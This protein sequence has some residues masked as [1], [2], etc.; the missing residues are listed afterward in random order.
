MLGCLGFFGSLMCLVSRLH[1][2]TAVAVEL[3]APLLEYLP[4]AEAG[5]AGGDKTDSWAWK[6]DGTSFPPVTQSTWY[7]EISR[8]SNHSILAYLY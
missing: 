6:I 2:I 7:M 1:E 4:K 5:M 3:I 8:R